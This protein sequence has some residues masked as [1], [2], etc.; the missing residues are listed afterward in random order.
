MT[1]FT[2]VAGRKNTETHLGKKSSQLR[3]AGVLQT[4]PP[5]RDRRVESEAAA[6]GILHGMCLTQA[7]REQNF[8]SHERSA[9]GVRKC[10]AQRGE[11]RDDVE[12]PLSPTD[13][14]EVVCLLAG[15]PRRTTQL[16]I[17]PS[18]LFPLIYTFICQ[19]PKS[20]L[21]ILACAGV[22]L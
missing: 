7:P 21:Q 19:I 20:T 22:H 12:D 2:D 1:S 13:C 15:P 18:P 5:A 11:E 17:C 8:S 14:S 10:G 3:G 4:A 9:G 6:L 16:E